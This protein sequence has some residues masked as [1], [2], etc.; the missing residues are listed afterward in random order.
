MADKQD[1]EITLKGKFENGKL[2]VDTT[3]K[4]DK[5]IKDIGK[6]ANNSEK[7]VNGFQKGLKKLAAIVGVAYLANQFKGLIK[8]SLQAAGAME[9]VDIAFTTMLGSAEKAAQLQK[10]LIEFAKKTPFEIEGIFSTTKQL[11]AY[12]IAQEDIIKTMSTLGNIASG[13]G[14]NMQRLALVF[15]QVRSTGRLLGQDLNQ[16]TQAGVPLLA[17]LATMLG[18][19][20]ADVLKLKESGGISFDLV[21][22]ALE[23]MTSEGGRFFNLMQ[24]QSKTFLGTLSNMAD[25]FYEVRVAL[26]NALLPVAKKVVNYMIP[27]FERLAKN[28][29]NNSKQI[30][31]F[32]QGFLTTLSYVTKFFKGIFWMLKVLGDALSD[33]V[34]QAYDFQLRV[35]K[36]FTELKFV[37]LD[38]VET[39]LHKLSSL[40]NLP[41]FKWING[42]IK[43][44]TSLKDSVFND[45]K[46]IENKLEALNQV[47]SEAKMSISIPEQEKAPE[48]APSDTTSTQT[49]ATIVED[50]D[51]IEKAKLKAAKEENAELEAEQKRFLEGQ[52]QGQSESDA[53]LAENKLMKRQQEILSQGEFAEKKKELD[54]QLLDNEIGLE[55]YKQE[56]QSVNNEA[57]L[58]AAQ[59]QYGAELALF[60]E[61]QAL[62]DETKLEMQM[63]Q[64]ESELVQLQLKLDRQTLA[65][66]SNNARLLAAKVKLEK[67]KAKEETKADKF[68]TFMQSKEMQTAEKGAAAMVQLQNSKNKEV[69]A[70]GKAAAIFQITMDTARGAMSAYS[71][72]AMIPF[73]GPALGAAAA[74]AVIAYGAEQLSTAQSNS[75]AVGTPNIP[76]DQL[77]NVHRG[78]MIVP[79]SFSEAIRSGQL[80][81]SGSG[82]QAE[83]INDSG[84]TITN[85]N[86]SMDGAQFI[87]TMEDDDIVNIAERMGQL[88]A[89]DIIPALPNN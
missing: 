1:V 81:L 85:I 16:F 19:T 32:A 40:S 26:G 56:L 53:I 71:A 79:A 80:T 45:I 24:N 48:V 68:K 25:G 2:L 78:E 7:S 82:N 74:A 42:A 27:A 30:A 37:I 66:E 50:P 57:K 5:N 89:E 55:Q 17:E 60:Q 13:V 21:K 54:Q 28:I 4:L 8:G 70:I 87:G 22:Q 31:E 46:D 67:E 43:D 34:V 75:F 11:L 62:M 38:F 61:N 63:V 33:L 44:F 69:A 23:N 49:V 10:D 64:D 15:G 41:G 47:R 65:Q 73:V 77:A 76:Q 51:L 18:K 52:I 3:E 20:E 9:Q 72:L 36:A 59:E 83:G 29:K 86:I 58:E 12:G 6:S 39:V 14:V 35:S 84:A 88:I